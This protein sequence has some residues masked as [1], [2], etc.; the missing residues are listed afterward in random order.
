MTDKTVIDLQ[1]R[2]DKID[3]HKY[4]LLQAEFWLDLFAYTQGR[5][6]ESTDELGA[7]IEQNRERLPAP[8]TDSDF[9]RGWLMRRTVQDEAA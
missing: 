8:S 9:F 6:S 7:W 1:Q 2:Q 5:P 4:R 3:A